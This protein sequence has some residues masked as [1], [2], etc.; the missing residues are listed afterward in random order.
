MEFTTEPSVEKYE[1]FTKI[2]KSFQTKAQLWGLRTR[3]NYTM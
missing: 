1:T 3:I 2:S